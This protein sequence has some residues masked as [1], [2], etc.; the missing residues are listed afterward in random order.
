MNFEELDHQ[1]LARYLA[2][3]CTSREEQKVRDWIEHS[4]R[5]AER[6]KEY[7]RVWDLSADGHASRKDSFDTAGEWKRMRARIA[8]RQ[9]NPAKHGQDST[10][11]KDFRTTSLHSATQMFV[12]V[13][14]IFLV[15]GF[16]G[17]YAYQNFYQP[18]PKS[19]ET[20]LR[21][22]STTKG[23]RV[24]MTL[25]DGSSVMLNAES[26][27]RL[28]RE[29]EPEVR[30]VFLEGE[31]YFEVEENPQ[32][33]FVIHSRQSVVQ[34]LGTAF[35]VRSYPEDERVRVVVKEGR[36]AFS[37]AEGDNADAKI[38]GS[39]EMGLFDIS[40][41]DVERQTVE[42]LELYLSWRQGY[43]KFEESSMAEV[44]RSLERRY[45]VEVVFADPQLE[46]LSLTAFLKSR[47]IR[48]VLEVITTSLEMEYELN[49][50]TVTFRRN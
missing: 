49:D 4:A 33:P 40:T 31:A 9:D 28:P 41:Q 46:E 24:N 26:T 15:A 44:A 21:E 18:E 8:D 48:N 3:E 25:G 10:I 47:S 23:Q 1:L 50:N 2:G 27:L 34:V 7:K 11:R 12:R 37:A 38:L 5:N 36:V 16:I 32:K 39:S 42:D 45:D 17:F 43:L 22:V 6:F 35:S 30:E 13:A 29:F 19:Q 14:A 20:V